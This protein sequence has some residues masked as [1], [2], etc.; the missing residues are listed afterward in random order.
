MVNKTFNRPFEILEKM[1]D[2]EGEVIRK[3]LADVKPVNVRVCSEITLNSGSSIGYHIH[4]NETEIYYI[5]TGTG[6]YT[7]NDKVI[8][9]NEGDTAICASGEGHSIKNIG[10]LPLK[11]FAVIILE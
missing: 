4:D 11:F 5:I 2:G 8:T 1:F 3:E 9:V 10:N 6:E 7:D